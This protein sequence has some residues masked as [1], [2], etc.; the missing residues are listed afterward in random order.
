MKQVNKKP[1]PKAVL[2]YL[3]ANG[4][5]GGSAKT[6][7]KCNASRKNGCA[8]CRP[9]KFRGRPFKIVPNQVKE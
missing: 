1:L 8:P 9:G 2:D 7:K 5:K 4:I 3:S 6:E